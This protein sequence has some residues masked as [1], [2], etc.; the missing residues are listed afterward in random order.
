MIA[1]RWQQAIASAAVAA[2]FALAL[3]AAPSANAQRGGAR[4]APEIGRP[5]VPG[6]PGAR[7]HERPE[8]HEAPPNAS[9]QERATADAEIVSYL[10]SRPKYAGGR[11]GGHYDA[12]FAV[13]LYLSGAAT[14]K[15]AEFFGYR[16]QLT[17]QWRLES[18]DGERSL[19]KVAFEQL[20]ALENVRIEAEKQA[21]QK[22]RD[23]ELEREAAQLDVMPRELSPP[24]IAAL[25][26]ARAGRTAILDPKVPSVEVRLADDPTFDREIVQYAWHRNATGIAKNAERSRLHILNLFRDPTGDQLV[27]RIDE[28]LARSGRPDKEGPLNSALEVLTKMLSGARG[29]DVK[30][31]GTAV[32]FRQACMN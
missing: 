9:P 13:A 5:V 16:D 6:G 14:V 30:D 31:L 7:P 15:A 22:R 23:A 32:S 24:A 19:D 4:P 18:H 10:R 11:R 17:E 8:P 3:G 28:A 29:F 20:L 1:A 21:E 12:Q 27:D 2:L 26:A 25:R